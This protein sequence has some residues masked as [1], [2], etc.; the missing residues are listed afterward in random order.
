MP[1]AATISA[2]VLAGFEDQLAARGVDPQDLSRACGLPVQV[3][4]DGDAEIPLSGFVRLLQQGARSSGDPAFGW[5]AGRSFDLLSLGML[6]EAILA[7]PDLGS[8][9][10]TFADFLRLI[11]SVS[12]LRLE[13]ENGEA[14]LSYRI[15]DPDIWPRQQDAE[16]SLS[17]F[18][19][20]IRSCTGDDWRPRAL[21]FEHG[22]ARA[23]D[24]WQRELKGTCRFGATSNAITLTEGLLDRPM[25]RGD[26]RTWHR[27][28]TALRRAVL[29]REHAGPLSDRVASAILAALGQE[30]IDQTRIA[31][32]LGLSRR[33]LRRKLEAEGTSFA[34]VLWDCRFRLAQHGLLHGQRPL[35]EIALDLG[36]SDQS[37]FARAFKQHSGLTPGD[38]RQRQGDLSD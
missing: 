30:P 3:W 15:L 33:S 35:S 25:P 17:I 32:K 38:Y 28:S 18:V 11:Q 2:N 23:E 31:G 24:D 26:R 7:A 8:A 4:R 22:P 21:G 16:F 10:S 1:A 6:G 29:Q 34:K 13:V 9:L 12:E 20:L 19:A 27:R 36:Y 14:L 37:A 5:E